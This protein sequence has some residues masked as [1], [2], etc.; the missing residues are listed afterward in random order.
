YSHLKFD[1]N[2]VNLNTGVPDIREVL[3][4]FDVDRNIKLEVDIKYHTSGLRIKEISGLVGQG[5]NTFNPGIITREI[6][7]LPD[8]KAI[9]GILNNGYIPSVSANGYSHSETIKYLY[10]AKFGR[11]DV[12]FDLFH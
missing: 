9:Y 8:D 5:W 3:Y 6:N 7:G 1:I 4:T 10:D 12:E 2:P 11:E